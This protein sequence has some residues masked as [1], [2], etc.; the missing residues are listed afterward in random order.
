MRRGLMLYAASV[1]TSHGHLAE[2]L[3]CSF[4]G[5]GQRE[6]RKLI[7]SFGGMICDECVRL[8]RDLVGTLPPKFTPTIPRSRDYALPASGVRCSF[9][10]FHEDQVWKMV[11]GPDLAIC[12]ECIGLC[13][14]I[15]A[16]EERART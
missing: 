10:N 1:A 14:E 13:E 5:K 9:C 11:A 8:S 3:C 2:N 12:D 15:I 16:E 7:R 6:V 4:C